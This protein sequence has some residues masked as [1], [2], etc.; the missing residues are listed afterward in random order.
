MINDRKEKY[1]AWWTKSPS[2]AHPP[3]KIKKIKH[4]PVFTKQINTPS[5]KKQPNPDE[6]Y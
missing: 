1:K 3:T 4:A 2:R 5:P 6:S